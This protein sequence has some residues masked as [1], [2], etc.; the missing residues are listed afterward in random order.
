CVEVLASVGANLNAMRNDGFGAR[1]RIATKGGNRLIAPP[2]K[3][4]TLG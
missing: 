3:I 4:K 1:Y 2:D